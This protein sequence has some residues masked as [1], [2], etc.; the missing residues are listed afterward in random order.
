[1]LMLLISPSLA[2]FSSALLA[3]ATGWANPPGDVKHPC[4]RKKG[5]EQL[6]LLI[7]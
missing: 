3:L 7:R 1:M 5:P 6:L 4:L 2:F